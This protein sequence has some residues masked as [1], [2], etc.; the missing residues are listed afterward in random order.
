MWAVTISILSLL[1]LGLAAS[2][3]EQFTDAGLLEDLGVALP[4][5]LL[6]VQC[7]V[8]SAE[9]LRILQC[10]AQ[11]VYPRVTVSPGSNLTVLE[12]AKEPKLRL[13]QAEAGKL[14]TLSESNGH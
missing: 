13:P 6:Q 7:S 8:F 11:V 10:S 9:T 14:Y 1:S 5:H 3:Q 4:E 12:A 2:L